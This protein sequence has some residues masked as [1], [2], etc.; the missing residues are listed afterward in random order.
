MTIEA[1][2]L[3]LMRQLRD[4]T[5]MSVLIITHNLGVVA[6]LCDLV[7][8]MYAGRI[9]E[10]A[11]TFD[12]FDHTAH[13]YTRGLLASIPRIGANPDR[14]HTI[15]GVVPNLLHLP[16]GCAFCNRCELADEACRTS[17]PELVEVGP[18]HKARCLRCQKGGNA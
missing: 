13:P 12:L 8:V 2:I 14:L 17:S 6:E 4:E 7:Y 16:K 1:Q 5:G 10:Q 9:V 11:E 15:P 18:R 3:R